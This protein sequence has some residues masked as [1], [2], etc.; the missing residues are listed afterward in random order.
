MTANS[1]STFSCNLCSVV[2]SVVLPETVSNFHCHRSQQCTSCLLPLPG[3]EEEGDG[4][5]L[6]QKVVGQTAVGRPSLHISS[7]AKFLSSIF[8]LGSDGSNT[9]EFFAPAWS[10]ILYNVTLNKMP[11]WKQVS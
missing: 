9:K 2:T 8:N 1:C 10:K 6:E 4:G 5:E 7:S 3:L 11:T